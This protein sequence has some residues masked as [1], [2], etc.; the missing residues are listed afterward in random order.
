LFW[1][2]QQPVV[3]LVAAGCIFFVP[4][5]KEAFAMENLKVSRFGP[6]ALLID[7]A[8]EVDDPLPGFG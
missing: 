4:P 5:A 1:G 6:R 7:F 3:T 8:E 2:E